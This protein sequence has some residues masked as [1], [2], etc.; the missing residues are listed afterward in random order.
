MLH[1]VAGETKG[2]VSTHSGFDLMLCS[3]GSILSMPHETEMHE[4]WM[5]GG[6]VLK[7]FFPLDT[8]VFTLVWLSSLDW[9][10]YVG[11]DMLLALMK[12][13]NKTFFLIFRTN[14][15]PNC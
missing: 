13:L 1:L 14:S 7:G 6:I 2:D 12:H 4:K 10:S 15:L 3:D 9:D 11:R 8:Q 5:L